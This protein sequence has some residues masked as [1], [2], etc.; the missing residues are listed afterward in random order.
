MTKL[1]RV[2]TDGLNPQDKCCSEPTFKLNVE[3]ISG[4][5]AQEKF[6]KC[7]YRVEKK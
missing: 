7:F 1:E 6:T 2:Q 5:K 3:Y 4:R